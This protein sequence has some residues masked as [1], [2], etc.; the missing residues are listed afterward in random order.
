MV[1]LALIFGSVG[2]NSQAP[3]PKTALLATNFVLSKPAQPSD[4]VEPEPSVAAA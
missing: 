4:A 1:V 2:V 3:H